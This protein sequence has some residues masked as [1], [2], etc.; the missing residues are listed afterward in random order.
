MAKSTG[1]IVKAA[2]YPAIGIA[3]VGNSPNEFFIG[4]EVTTPINQPTGYYKDKSGALKRQAARFRVYGL[5]AQGNVV[6]ELTADDAKITWSVQ[7]ANRKAAWY[8]FD[9]ALD[10][11]STPP[12]ALR[13]ANYTGNDR[14]QLEISPS[15]VSI[16]GKNAQGKKF[17]FDDGKFL[18]EPV[19]LGELR[20]DEAGRL[21]FLGGHGISNSPF[22]NNPPTTFA[23]NNG[24]HD[25]TSDGP[26]NAEVVLDG[27]SLPV[28]GAWV[29]TAPPN[30]GP[31]II[32]VVTM[33][34][35]MMDAFS[36]SF[37]PAKPKPSFSEDI[38][39]LLQQ[40][41]MAQWVNFGFYVGFGYGG[42]YDFEN[43]T[44]ISR[45][46]N[47]D[48][49][50]REFRRQIF[51]YFRNPNGTQIDAQAWPWM[52]GDEVS[53]PAT[54]PDAYMSVTPTLYRYLKQWVAG[55]FI[56]DWDPTSTAPKSLS[57]I[58]DPEA[59]AEMLTKSAM[60]FCLGGA[61]HPGCEMTWPMRHTT[62]YSAPFRI[63]QRS[64][65]NPEP[66]YGSQLSHDQT[67]ASDGPLYYQAPGD[68][69][70]WM[71]VPWQTDTASCRAG[72]DKSYDPWVPTFWPARVPNHVLTEE[73]YQ[74]VMNTKL[75]REERLEA[76]TRRASWYRIL[77]E[78]YLSQVE[79]MVHLY[80]EMGV[81]EFRPGIPNDP[82]FPP[83]M[84]V[85]SVPGP[86]QA[87]ATVKG[88]KGAKAMP[89]TAAHQPEIPLDR[90]L[91]VGMVEKVMGVK[92]RGK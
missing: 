35:V 56:A 89:K 24:W 2:I 80:G 30:Y 17:Q 87:P 53:I 69:S 66:N 76:F 81:V 83:V 19:Y 49:V 47:P 61:F 1:S 78:G 85:E 10:L 38:Y 26:V 60:W 64:S 31:D 41:S 4:P 22:P 70:R 16:T 84:Y 75:P 44:L 37:F 79:K 14:A 36:G 91:F 90:G 51:N 50:F 40:F 58:S 88:A 20:T 18:G 77:G 42:P 68:I 3:R 27:K 39:P 46:S 11:A 57:D 15:P 7:V 43:T 67:L 6:K 13:N 92:N 45:L 29:V 52:Y 55:D 8:E 74:K 28:E 5:D 23:N 34:D 86:L 73:D 54:T 9:Q 82:D 32:G 59:Q 65:N 21:L 62:L 25:D 72:Y 12:A 33:W 63:R 71:A 48:P